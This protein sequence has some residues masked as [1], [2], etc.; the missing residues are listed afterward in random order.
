MGV[1][2]SSP[3]VK[4]KEWSWVKV[5]NI[6]HNYRSEQYDFVLDKGTIIRLTGLDQNDIDNIAQYIP[7][8][9]DSKSAESGDVNAIPLMIALILAVDVSNQP[10]NSERINVIFHL[11][12]FEC[13]GRIHIDEMTIL[14]L[15][16]FN[17]C[18][19][20]IGIRQ[21]F[22]DLS[23]V[24]KMTALAFDNL[25]RRSSSYIKKEDFVGWAHGILGMLPKVDC[26]NVAAAIRDG[27][28]APPKKK[29]K[30]RKS[31]AE[32]EIKRPKSTAGTAYNAEAIYALKRNLNSNILSLIPDG[33]RVKDKEQH[34]II[35]Y[36][37]EL[38]DFFDN[39]AFIFN[40]NKDLYVIK[41]SLCLS[42]QTELSVY[43]FSSE[44]QEKSLNIDTIITESGEETSFLLATN[45]DLI[46]IQTQHTNSYHVEVKVLSAAFNY[47]QYVLETV[48]PLPETIESLRF[49]HGSSNDDIFVISPPDEQTKT[50]D[51]FILSK[52]SNYQNV[53]AQYHSCPIPNITVD[54]VECTY[55]LDDKRNIIIL[56]SPKSYIVDKEAFDDIAILCF[57]TILVAET[58]YETMLDIERDYILPFEH[59]ADPDVTPQMTYLNASGSQGSFLKSEKPNDSLSFSL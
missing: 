32:E 13:K 39:Y 45:N 56:R 40:A 27:V 46:M 6:V 38:E 11:F 36:S 28:H 41:K 7:H 16:L 18:N 53:S 55:L 58:D 37:I 21:E 26:W 47:Q 17:S 20:V 31:K 23:V 57:V 59:E 52:D 8:E 33:V 19:A 49:L 1:T 24:S 44:Y 9:F 14:L 43:S 4:V 15:M 2:S 48:T 25:D 35:T 5:L 54:E 50:V 42:G 22:P 30:R 10:N 3:F 29:S 34:A 51:I 12:D